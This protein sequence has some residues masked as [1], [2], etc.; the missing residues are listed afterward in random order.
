[1]A[2]ADGTFTAEE[3]MQVQQQMLQFKQQ[4]LATKEKEEKMT[5][6]RK[7]CCDLMP[8]SS[9]LRPFHCSL[10]NV[11]FAFLLSVP[12]FPFLHLSL[13]DHRDRGDF[14]EETIAGRDR[15]GEGRL[16]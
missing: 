11:R 5:R 15:E 13:T 7:E 16:C 10:L 3:F 1:M 2:N 4:A 8:L 9:V 6:G 12:Y 14:P